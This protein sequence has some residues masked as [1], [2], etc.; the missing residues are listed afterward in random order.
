MFITGDDGTVYQVAGQNEEGQ[1]ILLTQDS[2][3]Q[4][5]CLLVT[6]EAIQEEVEQVGNPA[7]V[8]M[9]VQEPVEMAEE[10][11]LVAQFIRTEPPSPG[12]THKVVVMLPDGDVMVTQVTPEEYASLELDK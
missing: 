6:S 11:P 10:Q 5:Q 7:E 1:T 12:G 8:L 2:D 9:E 4:Q 3:G